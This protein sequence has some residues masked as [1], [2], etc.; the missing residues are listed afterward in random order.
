DVA[1]GY[2]RAALALGAEAQILQRHD[3]GVCEAVVQ[4]ADVDVR[5]REPG[6]AERLGGGDAGGCPDL[7]LCPGPPRVGPVPLTGAADVHGRT[8]QAPRCVTGADH[9]SDAAVHGKRT[10]QTTKRLDD[11]WRGVMLL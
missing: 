10:V 1:V 5:Q 11:P 6:H 7:S 4:L 3:R 8:A 2:E 9:H